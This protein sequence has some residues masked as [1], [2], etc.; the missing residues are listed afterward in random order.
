MPRR[1]NPGS[2]V[3][4]TKYADGDPSDQFCI[5]F[6]DR[7]FSDGFSTR[8]LVV[9]NYGKKFRNNGF[10]RIARVSRKRGAWMV[11]HIWL[12]EAMGN[13]FSVWH[14]YRAPWRELQSYHNAAP[15]ESGNG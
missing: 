10:R 9:D 8:H 5:G 3:V 13:R 7:T 1:V 11:A 14:W 4:A 12:I 6:Y 2:Y 15:K